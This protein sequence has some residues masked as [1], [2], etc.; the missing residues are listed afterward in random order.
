M[1]HPHED[2]MPE[3]IKDFWGV[4][5]ALVTLGVWLVRL[6]S[7]GVANASE[8]KRIWTQRKEDMDAA[9][10]NRDLVN[11]KLNE[12]SADIKQLLREVKR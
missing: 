9:K 1:K 5:L 4:I 6:E 2:T 3:I 7:R 10:E 12:M 11:A 8:I